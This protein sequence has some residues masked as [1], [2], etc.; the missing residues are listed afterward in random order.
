MS[1]ELVFLGHFEAYDIHCRRVR[2]IYAGV[3]CI[4][5]YVIGTVIRDIA[6]DA[7]LAF[8][9][10]ELDFS[11]CRVDSTSNAAYVSVDIINFVSGIID[12]VVDLVHC[13]GRFA[14]IPFLSPI[15]TYESVLIVQVGIIDQN[16]S[17]HIG[18]VV[19]DIGVEQVNGV[20]GP[21][22]E[23]NA[24]SVLGNVVVNVTSGQIEGASVLVA[25]VYA[26]AATKT[27]AGVV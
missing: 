25:R 23:V 5:K 9:G 15:E 20:F 2:K 6:V 16:P 18:I 1:P 14:S 21:S 12:A 22:V 10:I 8:A 7:K 26:Y 11:M 3:L 19:L 4:G 27:S 17:T 13:F 24:T